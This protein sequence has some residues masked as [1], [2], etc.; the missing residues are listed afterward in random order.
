VLVVVVEL[1]NLLQALKVVI[2][3]FHP[4]HLLVAVMVV[5]D[6]HPLALVVLAVLVAVQNT[7]VLLEREILHLHHHHRVIT[8]ALAILLAAMVAVA[9]VAQVLLVQMVLVLAAAMEA[10]V[11]HPQFLEVQ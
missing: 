4:L 11:R 5:L 9:V 3:Y 6:P 8:E 10:L 1:R 7:K 2:L